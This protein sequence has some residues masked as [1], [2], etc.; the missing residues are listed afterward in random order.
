LWGR[1][2]TGRGD[3]GK[4]EDLVRRAER[5]G[6][7]LRKKKPRPMHSRTIPKK[8]NETGG[9]VWEGA[10]QSKEKKKVK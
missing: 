2:R 8:V 7:E 9:G 3:F 10:S 1:R 6:R 5:E 4:W